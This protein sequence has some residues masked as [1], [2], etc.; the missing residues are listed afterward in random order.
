MPTD[1]PGKSKLQKI[2]FRIIYL[3]VICVCALS[4]WKEEG[5]H[6]WRLS[7]LQFH[8]A[9]GFGG[10]PA[11]ILS[12]TYCCFPTKINTVCSQSTPEATPPHIAQLYR[13]FSSCKLRMLFC[14]SVKHPCLYLVFE[15]SLKIIFIFCLLCKER[16]LLAK[17]VQLLQTREAVH[18]SWLVRSL[19]VHPASSRLFQLFYLPLQ[20][21]YVCLQIFNSLC[22]AKSEG[23]LLKHLTV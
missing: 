4:D 16:V 7:R 6:S 19:M 21:I 2:L 22:Q 10:E 11:K 1:V 12:R 3:V 14:Y 9:G 5:S 8:T 20:V 17:V 23:S 13:Y 18:W 15:T